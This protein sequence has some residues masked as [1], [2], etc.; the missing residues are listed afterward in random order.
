MNF[1]R[2]IL[3]LVTAVCGQIENRPGSMFSNGSIYV[4]HSSYVTSY[5]VVIR[6]VQQAPTALNEI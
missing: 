6:G 3:P 5:P 4:L 2:C 1:S